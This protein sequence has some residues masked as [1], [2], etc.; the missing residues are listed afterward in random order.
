MKNKK[1]TIASYVFAS[2]LLSTFYS[3]QDANL[4]FRPSTASAFESSSATFELHAGDVESAV[5]SSTSATFKLHDAGGQ[6]A[7]ASSSAT[8]KFV[9]SGILYWL[10]GFFTNNY[11]QIHYRWRADDG[12]E[13]AATF[14]VNLDTQYASFPKNTVKRLRFEVSNEGWTRTGTTA[15]RLE[16]AQT[17]TC[18]SGTYAAVPTDY[19]GHWHL[20]TTTNPTYFTDG[21]A[22]TNVAGGLT[23]ENITFVPGQIKDIGNTT[24]AVTLA[25]SDFTEVEFGVMA[26]TAATNA[27]PYCFRLTNSGATSGTGYVFSYTQYAVASVTSG[28]PAT[29]SLDSAVFDTFNGGGVGQGPAYNSIMWNGNQ[30]GSS[31]KVQFQFATSD[32]ANGKTNP[33]TCNAG[34]WS[35]YGSQSGTCNT[36]NYYDTTGLDAPV[37]LSC[38]PAY[39]NNQR[40]FKYRVRICTSA[41]CATGGTASPIVSGIVVNW[42]P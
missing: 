29:G 6:N 34:A 7:T 40:Y 16:V 12:S 8:T 19:S 36:T 9:S 2:I 23:D 24:A 27:N 39:H 11:D 18:S 32:C 35:F 28:L 38:S 17:A 21:D 3:V 13:S 30:N 25:S 20:A 37:E 33:P 4:L 10:Y 42:A 14:P 31:G 22:T 41:D 15:F 26:L 5:A 1:A